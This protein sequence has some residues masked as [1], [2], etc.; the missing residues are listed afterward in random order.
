MVLFNQS[1]TH[2]KERLMKDLRAKDLISTYTQCKVARK[3][4]RSFFELLFSNV[5]RSRN[6]PMPG[7][8]EFTVNGVTWTID[9]NFWEESVT[10]RSSTQKVGHHFYSY[11]VKMNGC[12]YVHQYSWN[13]NCASKPAHVFAVHD[14]LD[15]VL[16]EFLKLCPGSQEKL[17]EHVKK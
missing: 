2:R 15:Q 9:L 6:I 10:C 7:K 14:S 8:S 17:Q 11:N 1:R 16:E 4:I 5:D 13:N 12:R 3:E